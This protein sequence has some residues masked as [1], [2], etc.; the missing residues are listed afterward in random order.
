MDL[1]TTKTQE[2][3]DYRKQFNIDYLT[4]AVH[5]YV[6]ESGFIH[7][8]RKK[9]LKV[10]NQIADRN[11]ELLIDTFIG[12]LRHKLPKLCMGIQLNNF[13][14]ER[15]RLTA[16]ALITHILMDNGSIDHETRVEVSMVNGQ[17]K[18]HNRIYLLLGG[19]YEKDITR[20]FEK[21]AGVV[22]QKEIHGWKLTGEERAFLRKVASVPY[23]LTDMCNKELLMKGYS[24]KV[25]WDLKVDKY[26]KRL[27]EDPIIRK[28]RYSDYADIIM[29]EIK[30]MGS[31]YLPAKYCDRKRV[32]Y[33]AAALEGI[34]PHG[35]LWETLMIDS[36]V[37]YALNER[38]EE[39]LKHIIYVTLHSRVSIAEAVEKFSVEDYL[40]ASAIDPLMQTSEEAFGEAILL[41]KC[42]QAIDDYKNGVPSR[43]MFGYDFTNSGL[44]MSGVSFKS[45][46]MMQ[47]GN[48]YGSDQVVDS[49][50]AFGE[51]YG[52]SLERKD[53]KKIHMGLM[54]GSSLNSIANV[55]T[56]ILGREVDETEVKKLNE[57]AYGKAVN[58]IPN[59][60]DWGTKV[61]GN[62][63]S[64]LRW[65]MPDGFSACSRAYLKGVPVMVYSAS[66]SHKERYTKHVIVSDM[67]WIE[68]NN[69]FAVY[70]RETVV[71]GKSYDV[72]QKRRG[73]FAN[74]T[75]SIDSYMLRY[76]TQHLVDN[77]R[78][79]LL[80]HDDFIVMP[81]DADLVIDAA[82][83]IFHTLYHDNLYQEAINE[84]VKHSPYDLV[85]LELVE[86][87]GECLVSFSDNFMMP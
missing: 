80:N 54:H 25:D 83:D 7:T 81:K 41:N 8:H 40:T 63:Q 86:G 56:E 6:L 11:D 32:Y 29:E 65:T 48:I 18:F 66:A 78:P 39:V 16:A 2:A 74:I 35:K 68:D 15:A 46:K 13:D 59:I 43:F 49:H 38:D 14:V 22:N 53:V 76:V 82:K 69:G 55:L 19:S 87:K 10:I 34:R 42:A 17:K 73:L 67:P 21:K 12:K 36:A 20:G 70:G 1:N 85:P 27:P 37:P 23:V 28:K 51:G 60:A 30:P 33:E 79:F 50:H 61:I 62:E 77:G 84:I 24:L 52:L 71:G 44:L 26:G 47:A 58:N 5:V 45:K 75:H 57:Q 9:L 72:E 3:F 4:K 31:F 64:V